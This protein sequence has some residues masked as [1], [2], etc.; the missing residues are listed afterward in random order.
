MSMGVVRMCGAAAGS[1]LM[2]ALGACGPAARQGTL[3][4]ATLVSPRACADSGAPRLVMRSGFWLNLHNFL[5]KEGKRFAGL[6]NDAAGARGNIAADTLGVRALTLDEQT[7]WMDAVRYYAATMNGMMNMRMDSLVLRVEAPLAVLGDSEEIAGTGLDPALI[8]RL[9]SV[10]DIYRS[11]WWPIHAGHDQAWLASAS[12]LTARYEGC[13][14]PRL[15]TLFQSAWPDSIRV[16]ASVYATW[17]GAYATRAR[18]PHVTIS[19][20]AIGNLDS[21]A[22]E[23]I[24]HESAH[25]GGLLDRLD[26][27]LKA[28]AEVRAVSLQA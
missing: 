1:A 4:A 15:A 22:L 20:N 27:A 8:A 10:A 28:R 23:T 3:D 2:V 24:L 14:F 6:D 9:Q 21:Y 18:G 17:F 11:V 5:H 26:S 16:D 7:R 12:Q 13:V 19:S 25:A